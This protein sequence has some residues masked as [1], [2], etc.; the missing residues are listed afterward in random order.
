MHGSDVHVASH[1]L[2]KCWIRD[3]QM[4]YHSKRPE[5]ALY[6][7]LLSSFYF[8]VAAFHLLYWR[9]QCLAK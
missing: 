8:T 4:L 7:A 2:T 9:K 3:M 5:M 1:K 6:L